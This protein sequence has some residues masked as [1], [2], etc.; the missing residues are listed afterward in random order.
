MTSAARRN[1]FLEGNSAHRSDS[2]AA[3]AC[4]APPNTQRVQTIRCAAADIQPSGE[5]SPS[6]GVAGRPP[7]PTLEDHHAP[8]RASTPGGVEALPPGA[9]GHRVALWRTVAPHRNSRF[10]TAA[11]AGIDARGGD[12]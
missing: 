11:E 7:R 8:I 1:L 5:R 4:A 3:M 2:C 9:G 12:Q 6:A 10:V